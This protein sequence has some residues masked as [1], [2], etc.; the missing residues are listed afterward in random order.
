[1]LAAILSFAGDAVTSFFSGLAAAA[2]FGAI[3]V[4]LP[5]ASIMW[6]VWLIDLA[7]RTDIVGNRK[8]VW[9]LMIVLLG[10]LGQILYFA[11][12]IW[13]ERNIGSGH[14]T[15]DPSFRSVT[16]PAATPAP[17]RF[18]VAHI[19][20]WKLKPDGAGGTH[21]TNALEMK[22]RLEALRTIVP[23][24][25]RLD[26]GINVEQSDAAWDVALYSEFADDGALAA[27]QSHPDHQAVGAWIAEIREDRAVVDYPL[28]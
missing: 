9:V 17:P 7:R 25:L 1:V 13:P 15:A 28:G 22:R 20:F 23:G 4:G 19:V 18:R 16:I 12:E 24:I 8:V 6:V 10:W 2:F 21:S 27:Y 14:A 3:F 11:F 26:V 5:V